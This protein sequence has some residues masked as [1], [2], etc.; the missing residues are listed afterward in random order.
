MGLSSEEYRDKLKRERERETK[1]NLWTAGQQREC[2]DDDDDDDDEVMRGA[3][4]RKGEKEE[5]AV[6]DTHTEMQMLAQP[7]VYQVRR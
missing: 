3:H 6:I 1:G 7:T 4:E 2:R 5:S